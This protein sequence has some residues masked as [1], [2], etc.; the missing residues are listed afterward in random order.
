[1]VKRIFGIIFASVFLAA[2]SPDTVTRETIEAA[3]EAPE[4][5]THK[6][7][8]E[9]VNLAPPDGPAPPAQRARGSDRDRS[10]RGSR[11]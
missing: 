1:M 10:W 2:C 5:I 6:R 7:F 11:P 4:I 8:N 9:L 3:A